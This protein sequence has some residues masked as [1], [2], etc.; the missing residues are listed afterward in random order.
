LIFCDPPVFS[1]GKK[2]TRDFDVLRDHPD[3]IDACLRIL[4][5]GGI[6]YFSTNFRKFRLQWKGAYHDISQKTIPEDFSNR[7]IHVCYKIKKAG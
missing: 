5:P 3:L 2:L 6:L 1:S 7:Q 4:S